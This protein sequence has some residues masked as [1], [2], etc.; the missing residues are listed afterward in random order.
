[1]AGGPGL[2]ALASGM[3]AILDGSTGRRYCDPSPGDIA[4]AEAWRARQRR[5]AEDEAR[6]RALPART[7][8]G[9]RRSIGP[10]HQTSPARRHRGD[11]A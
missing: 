1:M 8:P 5:Q 3:T 9:T 11:P 10:P 7:R 4:S 2:L 6:E